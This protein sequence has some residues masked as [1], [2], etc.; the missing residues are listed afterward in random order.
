[1]SDTEE[2]NWEEQ[3]SIFAPNFYDGLAHLPLLNNKTL[4]LKPGAGFG[5]LSHPTT[6]LAL[7][8]LEQ[9]VSGKTLFDIGSGSGILSIGASLLGA[10]R[11]IGI[12]IDEKALQHATENALINQVSEWVIFSQQIN[13]TALLNPPF[14]IIMNMIFSEQ[15][16]AWESHP[17]LHTLPCSMITS[18]I[19]STQ[20][21]A[22]LKWAEEKG[23]SLEESAEEE[24]WLAFSFKLDI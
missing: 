19:L 18:G 17:I 3:W 9:K 7:K 16:I 10:Q 6:R 15:K 20:K 23:W 4:L 1:M 22:Y 13:P 14:L 12:D 5:D 8:Y 21:T 24:G 2:I 11:A